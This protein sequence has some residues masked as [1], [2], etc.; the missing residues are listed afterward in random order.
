R[1]IDIKN[2]KI[3]ANRAE[4]GG[5]MLVYHID[6]LKMVKSELYDNSAGCG[7]LMKATS[8]T[9]MIITM[10]SFQNNTSGSYGGA[11]RIYEGTRMT[12]EA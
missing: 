12:V 8:I 10:C 5:A 1:L 3:Y 4:G 2:S 6:T 9:I 7:G 11:I